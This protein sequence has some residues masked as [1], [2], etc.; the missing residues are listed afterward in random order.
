MRTAKQIACA[1]WTCANASTGPPRGAAVQCR[2][3][4]PSR[5]AVAWLQS[6][7]AGGVHE[8][9]APMTTLRRA[10]LLGCVSMLAASVARAQAPASPTSPPPAA[11]PPAAA[12][13]PPPPPPRP[14]HPAARA[15][16]ATPVHPRAPRRR[17]VRAGFAAVS[18]D[19]AGGY[20]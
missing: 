10:A 15:A 1:R 19:G 17:A 13:P 9:M 20:G 5:S 16:R 12:P 14:P 4:R 11:A 8:T 6:L 3:T 7:D 2:A 18:D